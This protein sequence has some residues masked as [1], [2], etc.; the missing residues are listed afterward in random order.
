MAI[1]DGE[2]YYRIIQF[3]S[4]LD[5][6]KEAIEKMRGTLDR[7]FFSYPY[8]ESDKFL[9]PIRNDPGFKEILAKI[10]AKHIEF[11]TLFEST[12]DMSV[13]ADFSQ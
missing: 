2:Q 5:M 11:K 8:F 12:M 4:L 13:I 1:Y 10:K 3:Y 7:G 6:P 9:D